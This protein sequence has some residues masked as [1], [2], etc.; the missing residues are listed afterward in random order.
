M[1]MVFGAL[2]GEIVEQLAHGG[3][4]VGD[5]AV[6]AVDI[7]LAE[8][9]AGARVVLLVRLEEVQPQERLARLLAGEEVI[10]L[11]EALEGVEVL[12]LV[13]LELEVVVLVRLE[14][15]GLHGEH[16]R[17]IEGG[18]LPAVPAQ[19]LG[20]GIVGIARREA[21]DR[22]VVLAGEHRGHRERRVR[23]LRVGALEAGAPALAS[24]SMC[25]VVARV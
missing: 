17:R 6:V 16:G 23:R 24:A 19:H 9:V 13:V 25:G 21:R 8:V 7:G 18:R 2:P 15:G 11:I 10:D 20:D 14:L 1:T 5:L 4:G 3:V 22:R 12:E